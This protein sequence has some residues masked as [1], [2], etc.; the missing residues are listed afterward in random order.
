MSHGLLAAVS[1]LGSAELEAALRTAVEAHV[2]VASRGG[3]TPSGT[4]CSARR[5]TTTCSRASGCDCTPTS[6]RRWGGTRDGTAAELAQHARRAGDRPR[7]PATIEAGEEALAV[8]GPKEAATQFLEALEL[9]DTSRTPVPD[10]DAHALARRC[11]EA[12]VA[13]GRVSKAVKVLRARLATLPT[14][15]TV[16]GTTGASCSPR[17]RRH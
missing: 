8:G 2:L 10:V 9:I 5:S 1:D 14:D 3:T 13:A 4:R 11:A 16:S 6:C 7:H 15:G 12:F 17:S